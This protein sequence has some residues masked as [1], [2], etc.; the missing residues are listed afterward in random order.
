MH[1]AFIQYLQMPIALYKLCVVDR[2]EIQKSRV[3]EFLLFCSE[4]YGR[5]PYKVLPPSG[6][7]NSENLQQLKRL[8]TVC[9]SLDLG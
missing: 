6:G 5:P 3:A 9:S 2:H 7:G 1:H 4:M 8:F